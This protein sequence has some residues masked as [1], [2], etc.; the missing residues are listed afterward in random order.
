MSDTQRDSAP[1]T[2]PRAT[3]RLD[4]R[5][6]A[7]LV[8]TVDLAFDLDPAAT[9]VRSCLMLRRN[10][11]AGVTDAPLHLDGGPLTLLEISLN[12]EALPADRYRIGEDGSLTIP[13]VP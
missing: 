1:T 2:A 11:A 3:H 6:P 5:P 8:D 13:G 7:F 9:L 4:Y 12:R 10:P